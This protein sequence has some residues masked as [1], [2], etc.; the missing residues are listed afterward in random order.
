MF[1]KTARALAAAGV[2]ALLG[3][4][5]L[6]RGGAANPGA[7]PPEIAANAAGGWP[8][9]DYDLANTRDD[10]RT[11]IDSAN[12][13]SL[14]PKWTFSLRDAGGYGDYTTNAIVVGGVVYFES[15]Q[16]NVYALSE[17]DGRLLWERKYNSA[18]PSGGPTGLAVGYGMLF[19]STA[20]SAFA[21]D[22]HTGRQL[23]IRSLIG[24][25]RE[26]IDTTPLVFA[27][28]VVISTDPGSPTSYY[29]GGA[30][31]IVYGLAA[32]SGRVLWSFSTVKGG[33]SLW[34]DPKLNGGGGLWYPPA[35]DSE[36]RIFA[37]TGNPSP[38]FSTAAD[39]NARSRPGPDL[40]TDSLVALDG[41]SGRLLWYHQVTPHDV[42]DFDFQDPPILASERL[43]GNQTEVVF[44][45]GK[46]GKVLAFRASD[47]KVLWT[48]DVGRHNAVEYGALPA[49]P[50]LM[51]PGTLGGVLTPMAYADGLL[52]VPWLDECETDSA[53]GGPTRPVTSPRGGI[54][55]VSATSGH[56]IWTHPLSD[57]DSGAATVANDVVFTS[58]YD[59]TIY[60]LSRRTGHLLWSTRAADGVNGFPALT[61]TML[62]IGAGSPP[63]PKR[64]NTHPELI[65]Y[66]LGGK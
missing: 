2:I 16:A 28:K 62:I 32:G 40:Y 58:T 59:G 34:G 47:G 65:A 21:L 8:A 55:A 53:D 63:Y 49:K 61:K 42:R 26:G 6:A 24:N 38:V 45:A 44:G 14:K 4:A 36:G 7:P 18:I 33:G 48:L 20:T 52:Y 39:P 57:L 17:S 50:A 31:G 30:W 1:V 60:A 64:R 27:G 54:E 37:G 10:T 43:A 5:S 56:V 23:W 15:P 13:G 41:S 51:C 12:V 29:A 3:S 9:H 22:L 35:V 66:S 46:S 11:A 19:G 25:A